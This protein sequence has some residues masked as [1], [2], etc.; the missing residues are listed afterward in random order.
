M[1]CL[2]ATIVWLFYDTSQDAPVSSDHHCPSC[3]YLI[4]PSLMSAALQWN[5]SHSWITA[6]PTNSSPTKASSEKSS[7]HS[8][9]LKKHSMWVFCN[10]TLRPLLGPGMR[11]VF[12]SP[13]TL[14]YA[15]QMMASYP[16]PIL[17]A[18][19]Y[20]DFPS[21][22]NCAYR[23]RL[24]ACVEFWHWIQIW[25]QGYP[26]WD[27]GHCS[28]KLQS[29]TNQRLQPWSQVENCFAERSFEPACARS[30]WQ[31][32]R[33]PLHCFQDNNAIQNNGRRSQETLSI[34]TSFSKTDW[35]SA[36]LHHIFDIG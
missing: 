26:C 24:R 36:V 9:W 7:S 15:K 31:L 3:T 17:L 4:Q 27:D 1:Y 25:D 10:Q 6:T 18:S 8:I 13:T 22:C 33:W 30:S 16:G 23:Q 5:K 2:K 20:R 19:G 34:Q 35:T 14:Q 32:V 28:F 29:I 21:S 11:P 12:H